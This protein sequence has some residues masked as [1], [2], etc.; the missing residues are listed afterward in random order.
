METHDAALHRLLH[1]DRRWM[2]QALRQAELAYDAG[3]VPVGAVVVRGGIVVGKG[4]NMVEQLNDPTAHA[5]M[6][7][8]TAACETTGDKY[9]A[10]CT[11]YVT[12]EPCPMCAGAIVWAKV[13]RVVFGAFDERAGAGGTLY[14]LLRDGRLN[15]RCAVVSGVEDEASAHLLRS[16]FAERR[17]QG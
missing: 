1:D 4:R 7:A 17:A 9:L 3:E 14:N 5:E 10:D 8:V 12:L 2:K 16:F 15:H 13:P 11:L 6:I